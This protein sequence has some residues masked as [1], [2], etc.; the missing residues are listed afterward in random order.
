M[1]SDSLGTEQSC[2]A[3]RRSSLG[4]DW[5]TL[6]KFIMAPVLADTLGLQEVPPELKAQV[7]AGWGSEPGGAGSSNSS[8]PLRISTEGDCEWS[9]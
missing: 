5:N 4:Q 1:P 6:G 2:S 8:D 9:M 7:V 3:R